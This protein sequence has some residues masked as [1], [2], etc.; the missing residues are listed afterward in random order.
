M[1]PKFLTVL[2]VLLWN[3]VGLPDEKVFGICLFRLWKI[4][5]MKKLWITLFLKLY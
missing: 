1:R 2:L 3:A 4:E 5:S